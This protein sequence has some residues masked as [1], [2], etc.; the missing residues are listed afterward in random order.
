MLRTIFRIMMIASFLF[1]IG[2]YIVGTDASLMKVAVAIAAC[3]FFLAF[4][5]GDEH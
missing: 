4:I 5:I 1:L 2:T 3:V